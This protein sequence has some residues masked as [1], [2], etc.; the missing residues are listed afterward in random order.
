MMEIDD[1]S[2]DENKIKNIK[3]NHILEKIRRND[4]FQKIFNFLQKKKAIEIIKYNK[5]M[6]KRINLNIN[7]LKKENYELF[8]SIEIE[9]IPT[10]NEF[11]KFINIYDNEEYYHIY[12]N[13]KNKETKKNYLTK[14][15]NVIKIKIIIDYKITSFEKLF[16]DCKCIES[17]N[18]K[19]FC[20]K[21][22]INMSS[23][24]KGCSLLKTINLS[25]FIT[26]NVTNM[27][28]MFCHCSSLEQL[29]LSNFITNN[30]IDMRLMFYGCSSLKELNLSNF[31]TN[32]TINMSGMFSGCK[33]L[34][35]L[36][37]SNFNTYN[38]NNMS[39]MFCYC[40]SLKEL[41]LSNFIT[42]NIIDMSFM[43]SG[44]SSLY[45]LHKNNFYFVTSNSTNIKSISSSCCDKIKK[46][47]F[48]NNNI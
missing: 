30:V 24:F 33:S 5:K 35:N 14:E 43:F 40:S 18:F 31:N 1:E 29:N 25:N 16:E 13:D 11:T 12:F 6:L 19:K 27:S 45:L 20:R 23:M 8:T 46:I 36:N 22:I 26:Y 10:K 39:Y 44:C 9:I 47:L 17:I 37:L 42:N 7:D 38:V 41:N 21:N 3:S 15:D 34:Q 2:N 32:N 48:N 28:Y 4:I